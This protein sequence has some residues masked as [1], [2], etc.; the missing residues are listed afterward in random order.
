MSAQQ[1]SPA[2]QDGSGAQVRPQGRRRGLLVVGLVLAVLGALALAAGITA[3]TA[4]P[5]AST[6]TSTGALGGSRA[7][8]TAPGLLE[9]REG[10][11]SVEVTGSGEVTVATVRAVDLQGWLEADPPV[12]AATIG[13][14][15]PEGET[16]VVDGVEAAA[17]TEV[18]EAASSDLWLDARTGE[19]AVTLEVPRDE[20]PVQVV[21][22]APGTGLEE[23]SV[24]WPSEATNPWALPLL[25]GGG[26]ALLVGVV[27]M[28]LGRRRSSGTAPVPP[29]P[30]G[31]SAA[32]S[33]GSAGPSAGPS[34]PG[35]TARRLAA[36][37]V[38]GALTLAGCSSPEPL[39]LQPR[40][41]TGPAPVL[42]DA[43]VARVLDGEGGVVPVVEEADAQLDAE[44]AGQRL[45]GAP[46]D[47]RGAAYRAAASVRGADGGDPQ[48]EPPVRPLG[49]ELL[50]TAVP[51]A[52]DWPRYA[53]VVT[54]PEVPEPAEAEEA[55]QNPETPEGEPEA[56]PETPG[57][58]QQPDAQA[59]EAEPEPDAE[60]E[61]AEGEGD[62]APAAEPV[63]ILEVLQQTT[64]R[65][66]YKVVARSNLLPGA[67]FPALV[68]EG[69]TVEPVPLDADDLV[70]P[71]AQVVADLADVLTAGPGS[72]HAAGF[73]DSPFSNT[74]LTEQVQQEEASGRFV[75]YAAAHTPR[76]GQTWALRT[77]DGGAVVI[78]VID[79]VQSLVPNAQ[80]STLTLTPTLAA[81][82]GAP[83]A[84]SQELTTAETVVVTIPPAAQG[85]GE[86]AGERALELVGGERDVTAVNLG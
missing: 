12:E 11:A 30:A 3:A 79:G 66:D 4:F 63:P 60:V 50:V 6:A 1:A 46:L 9:V 41:E 61:S 43:Q 48:A 64:A 25:V 20:Q 16:L 40:E 59:P 26:A 75:D 45:A 42:T 84:S 38:L 17:S 70:S 22:I 65:E 5:V 76:E 15:G 7:V 34:A 14:V 33:A 86:G 52:G 29:V 69:G 83:T 28:V 81:I 21:A 51:E 27:L 58:G 53:V 47:A 72:P 62:V 77:D 49:G 35:R 2:T 19:G 54:R 73:A 32:S 18:P 80:G 82:A 74:V 23:L 31:G 55:P 44:L 10:T 8:V 39:T 57:A 67:S 56:A 71:P 37:P 85:S 78:A 68:A 24:T 36:L 13:G